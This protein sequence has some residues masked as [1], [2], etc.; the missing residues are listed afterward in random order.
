MHATRG[1]EA[2]LGRA[3]AHGG[4][5]A[6]E[7][8][9]ERFSFPF[10]PRGFADARNVIYDVAERMRVQRNDFGW[11]RQRVSG[12]NDCIVVER[13]NVAQGLRQNDVGG[14]YSQRRGVDDVEPFAACY[15]FAYLAVDLSAGRALRVDCAAHDDRFAPR[16][17]G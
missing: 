8:A 7:T 12:L 3:P 16:L 15:S 17:G 6:P 2:A 9:H 5:P 1:R 11:V 10:S 4:D 13:T 14:G